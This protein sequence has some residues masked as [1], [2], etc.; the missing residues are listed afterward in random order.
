MDHDTLGSKCFQKGDHLGAL[1]HFNKAVKSSSPKLVPAI[2]NKRSLVYI[3]LEKFQQALRDGREII[4]RVPDMAMGYLRC[5]QIVQLM[6]QRDKA[7]GI[8]ERGLHKVP[9]GNEDRKILSKHYETLR[10]QSRA[11]NRLDPLPVL[12][13]EI[14]QEIWGLLDLKSRGCCLSVSKGWRKSMESYP[15]LWQ[16]LKIFNNKMSEAALTV[17]LKR[18]EHSGYSLRSAVISSHDYGDKCRNYIKRVQ[19]RNKLERLELRIASLGAN[20]PAMLP[21]PSQYLKMLLV[22]SG[23]WVDISDVKRIMA[24]YT[25]LE[26][27]EFHAVYERDSP[28]SWP[29]MPNLQFIALRSSI[30]LKSMRLGPARSLGLAYNDLVK[31]SPNMKSASITGWAYE[32]VPEVVDMSSWTKLMYLYISGTRFDSMPVFPS[33]LTH[34]EAVHVGIISD[35]FDTDEKL[36]V[37]LSKLEYLSVEG[38]D[39]FAIVNDMANPGLTSGSLKTLKVGC[40]GSIRT[41]TH[42]DWS[43]MLPAPS[44]ALEALSFCERIGL[45]EKTIIAVLRQFPNLKEVDLSRT[46]AT[47][48]TLREL[49]ERENKPKFINMKDCT[50]CYHDAVEAAREAGIEVWHELAPKNNKTDSKFRDQ[51]YD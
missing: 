19:R 31:A 27:V 7:L 33:T 24:H 14:V 29:E 40:I 3:K 39:L 38:G 6:G 16:D 17:W 45:P 15:P 28:C 2:L 26:H 44:A 25:H 30:A 18:A 42:N 50:N 32:A 4:K 22:S 36:V 43:R 34:L 9:V 37:P 51:Y 12:P 47:G 21:V 10:R 41:N 13:Q 5:G 35:R 23:S 8:L 11:D 46:E 1:E 48:S 20:I 49:F